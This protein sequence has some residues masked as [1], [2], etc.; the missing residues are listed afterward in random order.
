MMPRIIAVLALNEVRL[1]LRRLGS[2]VVLLALIA[3]F[4][5]I[6]P[7][8]NT[9][10]LTLISINHARV[11]YTS[12]ALAMASAKLFAVLF[13][14]LG[15]YLLRGR[16]GEDLHSGV[17]SVIASTQAGNGLFLFSRWLGGVGY[18]GCL[19]AALLVN[20]LVFHSLRG[21]GP[22]QPLVYLQTYFIFLLPVIFFVASSAVLFDSLVPLMGKAGDAIYF[23]LWTLQ[24]P[25]LDHFLQGSD[26]HFA[27]W[28]L[29]DVSAA[30][31]SL[32][33]LSL[34]LGLPVSAISKGVTSYTP[35]LQAVALPGVLWPA[36]MV[37]ARCATAGLA[38]LPLLPAIAWFHRFSPD[39][40]KAG[41]ARNWRSPLQLINRWLRPLARIMPPWPK[42]AAALPGI[43][44]QAFA[45]VAL[46]L[47]SS[48]AMI[49]ALMAALASSLIAH[50][51]SLP[52]VLVAAVAAWGMLVSD[53]STRDFQADTEALTG[54]APGGVV[55]RYLRQLLA[56]GMLG[57]L[58]MGVIALR[59]AFHDPLRAVA[60]AAGV[61]SL[62]AVATLLGRC[63]RS[64]RCFLV[65]FL[66]W[67]Y[68][69]NN[70][71]VAPMI[72]VVGFNGVANAGSI[73]IQLCIGVA[74]ILAGF[75]YNRRQSY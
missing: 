66:F 59:W 45:D 40:V 36:T 42:L 16:V 20:M 12:S 46:A 69:A 38:L 64:P 27:P 44:G 65:L 48:P 21:D 72:D 25:L 15:F 49:A 3:I 11:L 1:R 10:T 14:L 19:V 60:L 8:P 70:V 50:I 35:H 63:S 5:S 26:G 68:V 62:S 17:G 41:N 58:F 61:L 29:G 67:L 37:L 13:G 18:L 73:L 43:W 53:I 51:D 2:L 71:P 23:L 75:V 34:K 7:D 55:Q 4:W 56:A 47:L 32:V 6:V 74:A 9:G 57:L 31:M 28:M 30:G 22:P 54:A 33:M 24:F 52:A 39:R